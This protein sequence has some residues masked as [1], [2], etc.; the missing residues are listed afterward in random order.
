MPSTACARTRGAEA[1]RRQGPVGDGDREGAVPWLTV[2]LPV[3][4][5]PRL[6]EDEADAGGRDAERGV[7]GTVTVRTAPPTVNASSSPPVVV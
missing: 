3:R 4:V 1:G 7:A 2:T 6:E 5:C